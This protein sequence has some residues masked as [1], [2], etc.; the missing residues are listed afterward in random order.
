M[1]LIWYWVLLQLRVLIRSTMVLQMSQVGFHLIFEG[2]IVYDRKAF[3]VPGRSA[4]AHPAVSVR[5]RDER[6]VDE[7][8]VNLLKWYLTDIILMLRTC[9]KSRASRNSRSLMPRSKQL[10]QAVL[11]QVMYAVARKRDRRRRSGK[12]W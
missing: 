5:Y 3:N 6:P 7:S 11:V 1:A 8:I 4:V 10:I 9:S 12:G 2:S